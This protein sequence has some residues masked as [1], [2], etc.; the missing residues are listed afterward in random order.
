MFV[1][2][3][4]R[5]KFVPSGV[6]EIENRK[7]LFEDLKKNHYIDNDLEEYEIYIE[8]DDDTFKGILTVY[9]DENILEII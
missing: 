7:N 6:L 3:P 9:D 8:M 2:F 4:H 1:V 5:E